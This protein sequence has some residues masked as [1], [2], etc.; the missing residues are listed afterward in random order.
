[1][2]VCLLDECGV[3]TI[4][5][6]KKPQKAS[7]SLIVRPGNIFFLSGLIAVIG[8][9][10]AVSGERIRKGERWVAKQNLTVSLNSFYETV[11]E[12]SGGF[13]FFMYDVKV[14]MDDLAKILSA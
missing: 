8:Q 1:M 14:P 2:G 10:G 13:V 11:R 12:V 3:T 9:R 7:K 4:W 6:S 5:G